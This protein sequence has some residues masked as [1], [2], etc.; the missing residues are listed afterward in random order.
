MSLA[1]EMADMQAEAAAMVLDG[2]AP[3]TLSRSNQT[4]SNS[5]QP[6]NTTEAT[7][8]QDVVVLLKPLDETYFKGGADLAGQGG[9]LLA[10][11]TDQPDWFPSAGDK[12][13]DQNGIEYAILGATPIIPLAPSLFRLL[14]RV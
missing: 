4:P 12:L 3:M 8:Q 11:T 10:F 9:A 1:D 14:I 2:G 6:W 7:L 5:A 13:T